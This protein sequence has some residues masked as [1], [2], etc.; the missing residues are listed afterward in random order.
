MVL[1]LPAAVKLLS[2]RRTGVV[3]ALVGINAACLAMNLCRTGSFAFMWV[4]P[5]L[6]ALYWAALRPAPA[7][8]TESAIRPAV[9]V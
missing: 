8:H 5:T 1:L 2:L 7:P 4:A 9:A 6:L 3:I